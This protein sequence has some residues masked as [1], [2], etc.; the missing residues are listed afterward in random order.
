M[1]IFGPDTR[2]DADLEIHS[3]RVQETAFLILNAV[4]HTGNG[5]SLSECSF[6]YRKLRCCFRS[7]FGFQNAV[8]DKEFRWPLCAAVTEYLIRLKI[9]QS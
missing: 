6:S 1:Q 9:F 8:S 4:S 2:T 3:N 5:V 7:V